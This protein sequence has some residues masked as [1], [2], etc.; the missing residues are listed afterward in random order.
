LAVIGVVTLNP[1]REAAIQ[2]V[3]MNQHC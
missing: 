3:I 2:A 1:K